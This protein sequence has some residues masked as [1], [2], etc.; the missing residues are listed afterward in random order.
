LGDKAAAALS[1]LSDDQRLYIADAQSW[2]E[3]WAVGRMRRTVLANPH[4]PP[5]FRVKGV[6][7]NDDN[8]YA[9]FP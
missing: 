6:L 7:R 1:G 2:R 5:K 3:I 4:S 9:A 8:W